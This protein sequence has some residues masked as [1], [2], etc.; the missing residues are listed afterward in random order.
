M[1]DKLATMSDAVNQLPNVNAGS[2][3]IQTILNT[4]FGIMGAVAVLVIVLAGFRYIISHG[5]SRLIEQSKNQILYAIVG[6][7]VIIFATAIANFVI[8]GI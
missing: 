2:G 8:K 7:V 6:L 4:V 1:F 5:D 3:T